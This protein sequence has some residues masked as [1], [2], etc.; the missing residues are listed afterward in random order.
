MK[1]ITV[2]LDDYTFEQKPTPQEAAMIRKR[3]Q[4]REITRGELF[5][6][7][8]NGQTV[9]PAVCDE[10]KNFLSQQVFLVDVD[11]G[12]TL[13][14]NMKLCLQIPTGQADERPAFIGHGVCFRITHER[15][16]CF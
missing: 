15:L 16:Q 1:K 2:L 9:L 14:E 12:R 7:L 11:D 10:Q 8:I 3:L 6:A 13:Q 4:R 5:V